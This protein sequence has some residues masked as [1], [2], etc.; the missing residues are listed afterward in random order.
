[1]SRFLRFSP[2]VA[3]DTAIKDG[4]VHVVWGQVPMEWVVLTPDGN[5]VH[6]TSQ[7]VGYF[8]KTDGSRVVAHDGDQYIGWVSG[9]DAERLNP[10]KPWGNNPV[11]ISSQGTV[12]HQRHPDICCGSVV[13]MPGAAKPTGLWEVYHNGTAKTMDDCNRTEPWAGGYVHHAST[14]ALVV[15]EAANGGVVG[16]AN[17]L[18][19]VLWDG[20]D[21][22]WPRCA[23]NG[24]VASVVC[25]DASQTP[26]SVKVWIGTREELEAL[27]PPQPVLPTVPPELKGRTLWLGYFF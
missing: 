1:M 20:E 9:Y 3:P 12:V 13:T 5:L 21:C 25:W 7:R 22:R 17:G 15:A 27:A 23:T 6:R 10:D 14:G 16:R 26:A 8:P 18:P 4:F 24:T 19:F 11:G 2:G